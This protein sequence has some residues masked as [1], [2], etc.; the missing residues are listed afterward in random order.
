MKRRKPKYQGRRCECRPPQQ[1]LLT[2]DWKLLHLPLWPQGDCLVPASTAASPRQPSAS[3]KESQVGPLL[4]PVPHHSPTPTLWTGKK[5]GS[6]DPPTSALF[7]HR[8]RV[9][10]CSPLSMGRPMIQDSAC[11]NVTSRP[12]LLSTRGRQGFAL[13]ITVAL[14][15]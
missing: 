5:K 15:R 9:S 10:F 12:A 3:G 14:T 11:I 13:V 6:Q 2:P 4:L 8:L 1:V 7:F